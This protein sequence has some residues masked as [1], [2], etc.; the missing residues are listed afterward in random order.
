MNARIFRPAQTAMQS[1]RAGTQRWMLEYEPAPLR[2]DSLM[3]WAST[4]DT[5]QQLRLQFKTLDEAVAYADRRGIAYEIERPHEHNWRS[6]S[7]ADNYRS[8]RLTPFTH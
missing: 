7:Y 5:H 8:E 4:L 3:G 1:G 6:M 2:P